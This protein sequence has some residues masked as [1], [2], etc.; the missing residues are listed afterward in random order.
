MNRIKLAAIVAIVSFVPALALAHT[1][2]ASWNAPSGPYTIDLG[3]DPTVFT[4]GQ[5]SRFDFLLWR[6]PANTGQPAPFSQV[7]VRITRA[8]ADTLLATGIWKQP[9]G[10]TTLL[11]EFTEP[12][13]YTI[14]TSYRDADGNDIATSSFPITVAVG[15]A[16]ASFTIPLVAAIALLIGAALGAFVMRVRSNRR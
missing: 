2:G 12:G 16:D 7:W 3:Y 15:S 5:Y 1:T 10:P 6:G 8:G 9:V 13:S 11:Y 4:A 14:E